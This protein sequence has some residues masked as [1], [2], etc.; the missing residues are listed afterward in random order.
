MTPIACVTGASGMIGSRIRERL[1]A[2]G[3]RVR[4]LT[5]QKGFTAGN[6]DVCVG[7]LEDEPSLAKFVEGA[8]LVVHCA[9]ELS[10]ESRM[11]PVN[12]LATQRLMALSEAAR[13]QT[14]CYLSSVGVIGSTGSTRVDET[15][16]C[17]PQNAYE[18]S[19]CAAEQLVAAGVKG[20]RTIILRPTNVV[21]EEKPGILALPR[22]AGFAD[23]CKAFVVGGECAHIVH[24]EDVAHAA[25][26]LIS[27]PSDT[28]P[29]VYI[30]SCDHEPLNTVAGVWALYDAYRRGQGD[31]V[32]RPRR[33]LPVMVPHLLRR[34]V[35]GRG[36][37]GD[38]R[39]SS[40]KLLQSGFSFGLGVRGAV[41]LIA[42]VS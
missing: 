1:T 18:K 5:R 6:A 41:R 19:K 17:D 9:A 33:H 3:H 20:C 24:A 28:R 29:Q 15:T 22:R 4:V 14:F 26:Y 10:D 36:N 37:R 13:V 2:Q 25:V 38:V 7:D 11:W 16:P 8:D 34:I 30:V 32:V 35:R 40:E 12:V 42:S 39:Y 23:A 31:A 27:R 21:D